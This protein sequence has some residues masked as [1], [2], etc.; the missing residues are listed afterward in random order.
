MAYT[1]FGNPT[2]KN[3]VKTFYN[4]DTNILNYYNDNEKTLILNMID[5]IKKDIIKKDISNI[6]VGYTFTHSIC[7]IKCD[8][9]HNFPEQDVH[10]WKLLRIKLNHTEVVYYIDFQN[11][12]TYKNWKDYIDNN[13][14]PK[15][16]MFFPETGYYNEEEYLIQNITP[17]SNN[18]ILNSLDLLGKAATFSSGVMLAGGFIFPIMAPV[19]LP[20][21]ITVG[22]C[23]LWEMG[24]EVSNLVD[25]NQHNQPLFGKHSVKHWINFTL[26]ALGLITAPLSASIRQ[27][28]LSNS[29]ILASKIGKSL[30]IAHKGVCI[31]HCTISILNLIENMKMKNTFEGLMT[32]RLDLFIVIGTLLPIAI[33][34]DIAEVSSQIY[35]VNYLLNLNFVFC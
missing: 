23:S 17:Y 25:I 35:I 14:L 29:A 34:Q 3:N 33:I 10:L 15:G 5:I 8:I 4:D 27:L 13:T 16:F 19:L 11:G 2:N 18:K 12:R 20:A 7:E 30:T 21:A 32:L 9:C 28:E 1:Y 26:A 22:A 24:R 6:D 31:T